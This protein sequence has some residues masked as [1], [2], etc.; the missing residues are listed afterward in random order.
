MINAFDY[1]FDYDAFSNDGI[2]TLTTRDYKSTTTDTQT[3]EVDNV[4]VRAYF[5][6]TRGV[7]KK[8][9]N[10]PFLL[11]SSLIFEFDPTSDYAFVLKLWDIAKRFIQFLCYRKNTF[12][13]TADLSS[14]RENGKYFLC[15]TL[16]VLDETGETELLAIKRNKCIKQSYIAGC[17]GKI[18]SDI[19]SNKLYM[20]HIPESY[21]LSHNVDETRF[22]M[23]TAAFESEFE[24]FY[25]DG[26]AM[27]E[28][29]IEVQQ[30]AKDKIQF[31]YDSAVKE[32]NSKLAKHYKRLIKTYDHI[33]LPPRFKQASK[34]LILLLDSI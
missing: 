15:A 33:P 9:G 29:D 27:C 8:I 14:L 23:I 32:G 1:H 2:I 18:L 17:E 25:P 30:A 20:R 31:L 5:G 34:T 6:V 3:F 19:A 7:S 4:T 24:R 10:P 21:H 16:Y 11:S 26:I 13:P 28:E 12:L 22:V